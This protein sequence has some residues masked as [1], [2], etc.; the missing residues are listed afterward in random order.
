DM[1]NDHV[2]PQ[3]ALRIA[4]N[5][6]DEEPIA[7]PIQGTG[8]ETRT[9]VYIDDFIDGV[10]TLLERGEHLGVYHVGTTEEIGI[11]DLAEK[12]A[13]VAGV[14]IRL[15]PGRLLEGSAVRRC[16]DISRIW[17]LGYRPRV[18]LD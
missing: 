18:S 10:L 1:G 7:L 15:L 8:N 2:I 16:P 6:H 9:F 5:R 13:L 12:V 3:I 4:R 14:R 11:K 17:E